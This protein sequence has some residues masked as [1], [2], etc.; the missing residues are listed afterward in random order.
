MLFLNK[1]FNLFI[2][3]SRKKEVTIKERIISIFSEFAIPE[4][5]EGVKIKF[6]NSV[7][8]LIERAKSPEIFCQK[9]DTRMSIDLEAGN[10][11]CFNCGA[12][13]K[14]EGLSQPAK[15]V[16]PTQERYIPPKTEPNTK[17][18]DTKLLTAIDKAEKGLTNKGKSILNL[19]NS[20]G[21]T[22]VTKEDND[23]IKSSVPGAKNTEINWS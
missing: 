6:I 19:A 4:E 12:R 7:M 2:M 15:T 11:H 3:K 16:S 14:I 9:C 21:Q 22:K 13:K 18:P 5:R 17:E 20:R 23:I 1:L 10:L 8:E